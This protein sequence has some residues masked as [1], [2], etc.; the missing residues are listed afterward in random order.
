MAL[1]GF[2]FTDSNLNQHACIKPRTLGLRREVEQ[3]YRWGILNI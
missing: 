3:S 1:M 2:C